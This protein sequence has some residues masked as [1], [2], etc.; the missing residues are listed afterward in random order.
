MEEEPSKIEKE[1]KETYAVL[2]MGPPK[3]GSST[4]QSYSKRLKNALAKD[5]YE[6]PW[7]RSGHRIKKGRQLRTNQVNFA[8][9]FTPAGRLDVKNRRKPPKY[10]CDENLIKAGENIGKR[11]KNLFVSAEAF[12]RI[13]TKGMDE[14]E[15]Y[16]QKWDKITIIV[17]YRRYHRWILSNYKQWNKFTDVSKRVSLHDTLNQYKSEVPTNWT[18]LLIER[19]EQKFGREALQV[20]SMEKDTENGFVES[21]FCAIPKAKNTCSTIK[22]LKSTVS[23]NVSPNFDNDELALAAKKAGYIKFKGKSKKIKIKQAI[24]KK[25]NE[26][27]YEFQRICPPQD[28]LDGIWNIT[29]T[30]EM[31]LFPAAFEDPS[32][33]I[34]LR[35]DFDSKKSSFCVVDVDKTLQDER[36]QSFFTTLDGEV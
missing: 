11:N 9:C 35:N 31:L 17:Y 1:R 7:T 15:V 4:I 14:L 22:G 3:T 8:S 33:Q 20:R 6:M 18:P 34:E 5:G 28:V 23:S 19:L 24:N 16:L 32:G 29:L 21:F 25:K 27:S 13:D 30:S 10:P 36:W 2:H 26:M 12:S